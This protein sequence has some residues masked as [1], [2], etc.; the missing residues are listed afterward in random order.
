[1]SILQNK[2]KKSTEN[3]CTKVDFAK[4]T[5]IFDDRSG[6]SCA[7]YIFKIY[8]EGLYY[9]LLVTATVTKILKLIPIERY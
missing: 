8:I 3:I 2:K 7:I 6:N 9:Y 5:E 1:M 4:R